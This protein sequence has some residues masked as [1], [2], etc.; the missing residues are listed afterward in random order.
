MSVAWVGA[1]IAAVGLVSGNKQAKS[2]QGA[3]NQQAASA[4]RATQLGY[5]QLEYTKETNKPYQALATDVGLPGIRN[6]LSSNNN[7]L[8]PAQVMA[9]PG[10]QFGLDQGNKNI[11]GTAAARGGLYSGE[12]L[13]RLNKFGGDY[14]TGRYNDSYNRMETA[15]TNQFNRFATAAGIGQTA[16]NQ[17]AGAGMNFANQ[18]GSNIIGAGNA[19]AAATLGGA[20]A[21]TNAL[22]SGISSYRNSG[23]N[24]GSNPNNQG[25]AS[26]FWNGFSDNDVYQ[27]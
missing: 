4:D 17:V 9:D 10:Y 8:T 24:Y 19:Q 16:N 13:R 11:Q 23:F 1:G 18:A 2:A 6:F 20:N 3:A 22:N 14:A 12:T 15:R 5:D 27:N 26:N 25:A 7:Q 21:W